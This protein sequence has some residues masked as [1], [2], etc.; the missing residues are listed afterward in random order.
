[1]KKK[2]FAYVGTRNENSQLIHYINNL[3]KDVLKYKNDDIEIE[4]NIFTA[5]N[6]NIYNSLGCKNCFNKGF[7]NQDKIEND[8]MALLKAKMLEADFLILSSPVYSHN[9]S[10]D[11]KTFIDRIS[12]WCHLLRL[13]GKPGLVIASASSNGAHFV[14]DYLEKIFRYLGVLVVG[15]ISIFSVKEPD[16]YER[17]KCA[18]IINEYLTG[19]LKVKSNEDLEAVF[20]TMKY[21]ISNQ[22]ENHAEFLYWKN[23]GMYNCNTFQEYLDKLEY[24]LV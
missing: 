22:S 10:G 3:K 16:I 19:N 18:K 14:I 6:T 5:Y 24:N 20:Q 15:R 11:T 13:A 7:C 9:V 12:Y 17:E 1:M 8:D 21:I 2:I 4:F 23:S